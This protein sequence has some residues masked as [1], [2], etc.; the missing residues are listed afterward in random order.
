MC[1]N[2]RSSSR[3]SSSVG[4]V[5]NAFPDRVQA[6]FPERP[7]TRILDSG[8]PFGQPVTELRLEHLACRVRREV[9]DRDDPPGQ[10]E[11][12]EARAAER[13]HLY[14]IEGNRPIARDHE[15]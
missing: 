7:L 11:S 2:L 4:V 14:F 5:L 8:V 6:T 12:G 1:S 3:A 13:Q 10:L 15:G 9:I